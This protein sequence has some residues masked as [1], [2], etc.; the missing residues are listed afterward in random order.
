M[1]LPLPDLGLE[2]GP[3]CGP[4]L[5]CPPTDARVFCL[6][7]GGDL[8]RRP[9]RASVLTCLS[10]QAPALQQYRASAG[11]P[12]NQSPTSP[13]SNQGFSPGS[14]PQVRDAA[15]PPNSSLAGA[16]SVAPVHLPSICTSCLSPRH[17]VHSIGVGTGE[18]QPPY[19]GQG[20]GTL[21]PELSLSHSTSAVCAEP[22]L[23]VAGSPFTSVTTV[24]ASPQG[25]AR[26]RLPAAS[27]PS[28][29]MS[30][31]RPRASRLLQVGGAPRALG[32]S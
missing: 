3:L 27:A 10:S 19:A 28:L 24:P 26:S 15:P 17:R 6:A 1:L 12:A 2:A 8:A 9:G 22:L 25:A 32:N 7:E 20:A 4:G 31:L 29:P 30:A 5:R 13:V 18:A 11:S 16:P 14:S 21:P 23:R